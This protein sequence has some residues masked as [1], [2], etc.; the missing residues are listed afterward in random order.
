MVE[1]D[2]KAA[3][4]VSELAEMSGLSA[5]QIGRIADQ[6]G[7]CGNREPRKKRRIWLSELKSRCPELWESILDRLAALRTSGGI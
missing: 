4:T 2:L 3:Y 6:A 1:Q 7:L 5:D